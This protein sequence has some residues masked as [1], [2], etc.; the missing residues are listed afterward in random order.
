MYEAHLDRCAGSYEALSYVWGDTSKKTPI[1]VNDKTLEIGINLRGA[2]HA[3]RYEDKSRTLWIDA[4]CIDQQNIK[5]RNEQVAAMPQIYSRAM[6]TVIW[7]GDLPRWLAKT[8]FTMLNDLAEEALI[9]QTVKSSRFKNLLDDKIGR[10][11]V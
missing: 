4:I 10:A 8:T 2:L 9:L 5:E 7:L 3:L 11:H 6:K 1:Q